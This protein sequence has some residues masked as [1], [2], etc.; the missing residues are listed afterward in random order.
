MFNTFFGNFNSNIATGGLFDFNATLPFLALQF[1]IL[2][3]VLNN[4]LYNPLINVITER[5]EYIVS[6]LTKAAKLIAETNEIKRIRQAEI[7]EA[8]KTAQNDIKFYQNQFKEISENDLNKAQEAFNIIL[9]TF[10]F[11][12]GQQK[13]DILLKLRG[14]LEL[15]EL[16]EID[17]IGL[18][19]KEKIIS[20][21]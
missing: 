9:A 15:V 3:F 10:S 11:R 7:F 16:S 18:R 14:E 5:N 19:I 8:R 21:N 4:I 2:M 13:R 1:L 20:A 6:N 17:E 12:L